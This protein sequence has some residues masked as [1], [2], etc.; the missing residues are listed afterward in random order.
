MFAF[1]GIFMIGGVVSVVYHFERIIRV[2]HSSQ[3]NEK[4]L[5]VKRRLRKQQTWFIVLGS[6]SAIG[7]LLL[8]ASVF[9]PSSYIAIYWISIELGSSIAAAWG[10][11]RNRRT[12][13]TDTSRQPLQMTYT[14]RHHMSVA[15]RSVDSVAV[16]IMNDDNTV[17]DETAH[18]LDDRVLISPIQE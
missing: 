18:V 8:A 3:K 15:D 12:D 1:E 4:L 9:P 14:K 10:A 7:H 2:I 13:R 16:R 5:R 11:S 6:F 17:G